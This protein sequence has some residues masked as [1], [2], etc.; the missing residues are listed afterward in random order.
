MDYNKTLVDIIT[1][2]GAEKV[3]DA[4]NDYR[5]SGTMNLQADSLLTDEMVEE[6]IDTIRMNFHC[7]NDKVYIRKDF[8]PEFDRVDFAFA[9]S[10]GINNVKSIKFACKVYDDDGVRI[11]KGA[12]RDGMII[13]GKNIT[14]CLDK[15]VDKLSL[16][17]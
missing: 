3:I 9:I 7:V 4:I 10:L 8:R 17:L 12:G 2:F 14:E 1:Q 6:I 13:K 15:F 5:F 11:V 16:M